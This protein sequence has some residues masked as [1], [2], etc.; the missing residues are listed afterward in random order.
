MA[1]CELHSFVAKFK[2]L[3]HAG[4]QATLKVEADNGEASVTLTAGLGPIAPPPPINCHGPSRYYRGPS[5]QRR[6][7]RRK[8][9]REAAAA[10]ELIPDADACLADQAEN[11]STAAVE[12]QSVHGGVKPFGD[13][14]VTEEVLDDTIDNDKD[15]R[16]ESATIPQLDGE[17]DLVCK[18]TYCKVCRECPDE[19]ETSD[20]ISYHVM[21]DHYPKEVLKM[22]GQEWIEQRRY[23]IRKWS[24]FENW[25]STP[26]TS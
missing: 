9:A 4:L 1:Y 13:N 15:F 25:F 16:N 5:Y 11:T 23:C 6:Q 18:D 3:C 24:P 21:N 19:M 2:F 20:D 26:F 14:E 10:Q 7:A 12:E 22:Y 17:T 8:A